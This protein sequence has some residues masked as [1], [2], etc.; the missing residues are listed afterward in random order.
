MLDLKFIRENPDIVRRAIANRHDTAPVEEILQLDTERRLKISEM[1][2][3]RRSRK[4]NSKE[5]QADAAEEGRAL[6]TKIRDLEEG[7]KI[8]EDKLNNLLLQ[9]P[10]IP[11][12]K[13]PL[14]AGSEDNKIVRSWGEPRTLNFEAKPHSANR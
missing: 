2:E 9:M 4:Q 6:R 8:T 3:V 5:R 10:N 1:E 12:N 13:V 11:S 7:V 14:G